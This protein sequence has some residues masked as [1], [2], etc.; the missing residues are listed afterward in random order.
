[1]RH[2]MAQNTPSDRDR[3]AFVAILA[4]PRNY[5]N[6]TLALRMRPENEG[7]Q[8]WVGLIHCHAV[9]VQLTFGDKLATFQSTK[10]FAIHLNR[11]G[12]ESFGHFGFDI[13]GCILGLCILAQVKSF[14][15]CLGSLL[16]CRLGQRGISVLAVWMQLFGCLGHFAPQL[17]FLGLEAPATHGT[18]SVAMAKAR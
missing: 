4:F 13:M 14:H 6:K 17:Q 5:Q 18:R 12:P 2:V 9:Q 15:A 7:D 10:G 8:G 11:R 16:W 1:M 3:S